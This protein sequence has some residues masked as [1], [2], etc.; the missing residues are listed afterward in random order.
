MTT[1]TQP[2][3]APRKRADVALVERGVFE[4][5]ARAQAAIAAGLVFADGKKIAKPSEPIAAD[6]V[7]EAEP[8][9]PYVSRGGVKLE[10]A[11][12]HYPIEIAGRVCLDVGASTGGFTDV[13]L[14]HGARQVFAVDVGH[15]QLHA[16]LRGH[17]NIVSMEGTD[18]RALAA[19]SL[20]CGPEVVV[21]DAS[22]ISLEQVL[23]P[24]LALAARPASL[25]VL[26]KPQFEVQGG[27]NKRGIIKDGSVHDAVCAKIESFAAALG[28]R[29]IA[30]FP[31]AIAG[32]DGNREFFLGARYHGPLPAR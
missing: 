8:A 24:A 15:D 6:A 5:R 19:G 30:I 7:I 3:P 9:H 14:R 32:G 20:P 25:L 16:S 10:G 12:K 17:P 18:I 22:F 31:S 29:D 26:I 23:P 11:L 2:T 28:C 27:H 1:P 13:L 4:S 21:I